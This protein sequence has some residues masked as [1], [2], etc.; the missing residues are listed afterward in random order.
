[1][2]S[3]V[4]SGGTTISC[5]TIGSV[6]NGSCGTIWSWTSDS[7]GT[8]SSYMNCSCIPVSSFAV[9]ST[10]TISSL[11]ETGSC[12]IVPS[13]TIK[14][15][16]QRIGIVCSISFHPIVASANLVDLGFLLGKI[17]T[18][19]KAFFFVVGGG[20]KC[21]SSTTQVGNLGIPGSAMIWTSLLDV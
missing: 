2:L 16:G 7:C 19:A 17:E 1:M 15:N 14:D 10:G 12:V 3:I 5:V 21:S 8:T 4:V 11:E 13:S 18:K 9:V 6:I 20:T